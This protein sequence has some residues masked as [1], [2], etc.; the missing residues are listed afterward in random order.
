M[1]T[2]HAGG[3]LKWIVVPQLVA[4]VVTLNLTPAAGFPP[5]PCT[6]FTFLALECLIYGFAMYCLTGKVTKHFRRIG[7]D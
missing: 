6:V 2:K 1:I 4:L 5:H 7:F 3:F